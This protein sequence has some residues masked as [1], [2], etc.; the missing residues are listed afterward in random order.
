VSSRLAWSAKLV[1]GH[2][3]IHKKKKNKQ[4]KNKK[5][6]PGKTLGEVGV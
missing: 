5:R 2:P 3:G 4:K 6:K 1:P